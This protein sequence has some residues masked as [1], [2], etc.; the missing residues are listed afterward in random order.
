MA[1]N[2]TFITH[3]PFDVLS[4]TALYLRGR[5]ANS[6]LTSAQ[7]IQAYLDQ[8]HRHNTSGAKLNLIVSLRDREELLDE[9]RERDEELAAGKSRGVFHGIPFIAK[10]GS[11][12][13]H[14]LPSFFFLLASFFSDA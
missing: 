1:A 14:F 12:L 4:T 6:T 13:F 10:V 7:I 2:T 3:P 11:V 5:L 8:I 9:A